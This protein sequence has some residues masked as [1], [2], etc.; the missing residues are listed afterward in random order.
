M[1]IKRKN[2][3]KLLEN[4]LFVLEKNSNKITN[5]ELIFD[6][7]KKHVQR[8]QKFT[9]TIIGHSPGAVIF[10]SNLPPLS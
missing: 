4:T 8:S 3:F 5:H 6:Q 9:K 7:A 2:Y 10:T 1:N